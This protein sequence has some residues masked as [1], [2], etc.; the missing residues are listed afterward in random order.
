MTQEQGF[1]TKR[2][3]ERESLSERP[4]SSFVLDNLQR[5]SV[6]G[7]PP[8]AFI[9]VTITKIPSDT[10]HISERAFLQYNSDISKK[11]HSTKDVCDMQVFHL[12]CMMLTRRNSP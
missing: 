8:Q 7:K 3:T 12:I 10:S 9:K 11:Q 5:H 1:F 6:F 2:E 4:E